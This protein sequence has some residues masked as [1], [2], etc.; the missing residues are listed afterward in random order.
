MEPD[1]DELD[2]QLLMARG[3][4]RQPPDVREWQEWLLA[5]GFFALLVGGLWLAATVW[6]LE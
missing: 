4:R 2:W 5:V 3:S 6:L 1:T